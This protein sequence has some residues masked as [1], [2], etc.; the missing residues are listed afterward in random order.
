MLF[1][2][3]DNYTEQSYS[4]QVFRAEKNTRRDG[5]GGGDKPS[6]LENGKKSIFR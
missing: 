6:F 2:A 3:R 4:Y 5:I 1:A